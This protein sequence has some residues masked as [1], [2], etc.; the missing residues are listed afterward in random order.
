MYY[1]Q[2]VTAFPPIVMRRDSVSYLQCDRIFG[3]DCV[4]FNMYRE[5]PYFMINIT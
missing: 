2:V 4:V 5:H 3:T 1:F